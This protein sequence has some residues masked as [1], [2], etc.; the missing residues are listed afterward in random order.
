MLLNKDGVKLLLSEQLSQDPLEEYFSKQRAKGG[1]DENPTLKTFHRNFLDLNVAGDE[2]VR[3]VN[4]TIRG[5]QREIVV[6]CSRHTTTSNK[7][8]QL[9]KKIVFL[10]IT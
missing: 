1:A 9:N 6:R 8:R 2:L 10:E 7:K 3:V 5:R 4:G